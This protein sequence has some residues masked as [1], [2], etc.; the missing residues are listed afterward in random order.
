VPLTG[1]IDCPVKREWTVRVM[2][3]RAPFR[4]QWRECKP[5]RALEVPPQQIALWQ[6]GVSALAW[7][8]ENTDGEDRLLIEKAVTVD[9]DADGQQEIL[10]VMRHEG[11]GAFTEWCLAGRKGGAIGCWDSPDLEAPAKKLLGSDEAFGGSGWRL[12]AL[13]RALRLERSVYHEGVDPNCCPTRGSVV[14]RLRPAAGGRL[15][16]AAVTRRAPDRPV[17]AATP[18]PRAPDERR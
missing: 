4:A 11:T 16:I 10:I 15:A 6:P 13:R 8:L 18:A 7:A 3:D 12:R 14:V 9:L 1:A 2:G 17:P 5:R